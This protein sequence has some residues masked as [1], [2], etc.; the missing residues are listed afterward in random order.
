MSWPVST[1]YSIVSSIA[2][3]GI[4]IGGF[5][6]PNWGWNGASG[7]A[8]IWAGLGIAPMLAGAFAAVCFLMVKFMVLRTSNPLRNGFFAGP[9]LFFLVTAICTMSIIYV[10]KA[11]S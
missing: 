6:A 3:V 2:G 8:A 7:L 10:S 11:F 4:A 5:D 9:L 1:T